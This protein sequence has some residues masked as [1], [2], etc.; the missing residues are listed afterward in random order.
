[1]TFTSDDLNLISKILFVFPR[2]S[3]RKR[4]VVRAWEKIVRVVKSEINRTFHNL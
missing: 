4:V 2:N 1:M 3:E